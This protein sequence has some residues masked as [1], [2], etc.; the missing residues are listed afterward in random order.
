LET[1][2]PGV[3]ATQHQM[4]PKPWG[5][6]AILLALLLPLTLWGSSL[7]VAIAQGT[8]SD[9]SNGEIVAGLVFTIVLDCVFIGLAAGLS[10]WRY[11]LGWGALGLRRFD[12]DL[13]WFPLAAAAAAHVGIV[14]YTAVVMLVGLDAA[15]PQQDLDQFFKSRA[16]LPL[17]G[18]A[19]VIM[20]PLAEEIFF[21]GFI[22]AG[23]VRPLGLRVAMVLSG[24]LF[25]AFHVTGPDTVGLVVPF[26][27]VGMLFAWVYYR[28][29]SLW[30]SI[31]T[32]F[33]FN[34]VSFAIL[35]S[36]AG[37]VSG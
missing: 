21:R 31:A 11:R 15:A 18:V 37:N 28:T 26:G 24:F 2:A 7:A 35:A 8:P 13:W 16:V 10:L 5:I 1:T 14:I 4:P 20:A 36:M 33:L 34:L 27:V 29:G 17:A 6:P 3:A 9:L 23:L 32:H 12:S 22:F 19:T 25:G 30:T